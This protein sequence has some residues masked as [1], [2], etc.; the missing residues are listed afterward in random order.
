MS[1]SNIPP[2]VSH[3]CF[4]HSTRCVAPSN[5][6]SSPDTAAKR[7]VARYV[8][9]PFAPALLSSCAHSTLTAT[10]DASS[11]APG[12]SAA[13]SITFDGRESKCPETIKRVFASVGSEPGRIAYTF[14]SGIGFPEVRSE[15][16]SNL[17]TTTC[18]FPPES[19]AISFN[20]ATITSRPHPIPRFESVHEES[21][22]RVPHPTSFP[23]STLIDFSS[24]DARVNRPAGRA[25]ILGCGF[26]VAGSAGSCGARRCAAAGMAPAKKTKNAMNAPD[27]TR[28]R[29]LRFIMMVLASL[30]GVGFE[31]VILSHPGLQPPVLLM[32]PLML[33]F[34]VYEQ[35]PWR[36]LKR[37]RLE[38]RGARGKHCC[39][40][41][42]QR[43]NRHC[44]QQSRRRSGHPARRIARNQIPR[45]PLERPRARSLRPPG[46]HRP[47]RAPRR[48]DLPG[49]LHAPALS[50]FCRPVSQS[51]P[52]HPSF[53][54]PVLPRPR[55][56]A[57]APRIRR[58]IRRLHRP[59]R[60]RK[61][62][63]RPDH[64]PTHCP[65]PRRRHG[66]FALRKNSEHKAS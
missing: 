22:S 16:D 44:H 53:A 20:R 25:N 12:A 52:E 26:P 49:R 62:R 66:S 56:A 13:G 40:P 51:H 57:P 37:P 33:T 55:I 1:S 59:F 60:R 61:S 3:C 21:V 63:R 14:S 17:S 8:P 35:T 45:D 19:F 38:L 31:R 36:P 29:S 43:G 9:R 28:C 30:K 15:V 50:V 39:G 42:P 54:A 48:S 4:A 5:P 34:F 7:I 65:R 2:T 6:C 41:H 10:P 18:N 64:H 23:I 46:C 47:R 58:E 24:T 11:S 27:C 32:P